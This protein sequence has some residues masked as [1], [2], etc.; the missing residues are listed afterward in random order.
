MIHDRRLWGLLGGLHL[1][2]SFFECLTLFYPIFRKTLLMRVLYCFWNNFRCISSINRYSNVINRS[3]HINFCK[4]CVRILFCDCGE[5]AKNLWFYLKQISSRQKCFILQS[6]FQQLLCFHQCQRSA[7]FIVYQMTQC[8]L[9][10]LQCFYLRRKRSLPFFLSTKDKKVAISLQEH[11]RL[12][13]GN[14][15]HKN[16]TKVAR[17]I[18][19]K[20]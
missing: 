5:I 12:N 1:P 9:L 19:E 15:Y 14:H 2:S 17:R 13:L 20:F 10:T 6:Y 3:K 16:A 4:F 7:L 11:Q 8:I 18:I